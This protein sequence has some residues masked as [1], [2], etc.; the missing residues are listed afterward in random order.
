MAGTASRGV[1]Y[2]ANCWVYAWNVR[3]PV[4]IP[5]GPELRVLSVA[6]SASNRRMNS[7]APTIDNSGSPGARE[8]QLRL[9]TQAVVRR[10]ERMANRTTLRVGGPADLY[11]EP[12]SE[13]DLAAVLKYCR[14]GGLP[15]LVL[16]RG[17]NLLVRD[18][19]YRGAVISLAQPPFCRVEVVSPKIQ[20]GAG[21]R[22]KQMSI[23][24]KRHSLAG[25]E[26]LEGIPGS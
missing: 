23:E 14:A 10:N 8:G 16:G 7:P 22:L 25:F 11:I 24:A 17:S 3:C 15:I 6:S 1:D 2:R 12:A 19:G 26:F 21:A 5:S 9:S 4:V 20:C 18:G 13:E